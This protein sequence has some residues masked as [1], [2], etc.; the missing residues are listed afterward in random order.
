MSTEY[1]HGYGAIERARLRSQAEFWRR[2]LVL[3]G[4]PYLGGDRVLEIGC[5]VG[6]VLS[7]LAA[8]FPGLRVA[9]ID[10]VASQ[11]GAA[12]QN[13]VAEAEEQLRQLNMGSLDDFVPGTATQQA[14]LDVAAERL[15]LLY[16]GITRAERELILTYN[17]G[18]S[19]KDPNE[20]AMAF[21][22]L[23]AFVD[24]N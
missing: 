8:G 16:V 3:P 24:N 11:I 21:Q 12:R 5:G 13:L 20:P 17:T 19:E 14:R 7:V 23:K 4:L 2:R 10:P 6:A 22:A 18:R 9:G 15:R 1:V